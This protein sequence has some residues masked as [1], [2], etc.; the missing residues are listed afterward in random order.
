MGIYEYHDDLNVN[1]VK[2]DKYEDLLEMMMPRGTLWEF[3]NSGIFR[4]HANS[5][6]N[7]I[8]SLYRDNLKNCFT[9]ILSGA[10]TDDCDIHYYFEL[11]I[12]MLK[13]FY[14]NAKSIGLTVPNVPFFDD[15]YLNLDFLSAW[16]AF[17]EKKDLFQYEGIPELAALVQHYGLQTRL[18]D[19][20]QDFYVA[21]YFAASKAVETIYEENIKLGN[22]PKFHDKYMVVWI[23]PTIYLLTPASN[24]IAP[25][26]RLL[27]PSYRNNPNICAQKGILT[28]WKEPIEADLQFVNREKLDKRIFDFYQNRPLDKKKG[29]LGILLYKI[30]IPITECT[31]IMCHINKLGYK[32]V[33]L[34]PWYKQISEAIND[35][36]MCDVIE[37]NFGEFDWRKRYNHKNAEDNVLLV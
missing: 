17:K 21:L 20:T 27:T 23:L 35:E 13:Y 5:E 15:E 29:E 4:G 16:K 19:W 12:S 28:Y 2:V 24:V 9:E 26:I 18:L 10:K 37:E 25:P 3:T 33:T 6:W 32:R 8:P 11:E 31:K 22:L 1:V 7:L 34:L 30:L 36:Y 14:N